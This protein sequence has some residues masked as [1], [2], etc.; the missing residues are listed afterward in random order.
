MSRSTRTLIAAMLLV[1]AGFMAINNIVSAVDI[2]DWL[3]PAVLLVAGLTL[4]FYPDQTAPAPAHEDDEPVSLAA[5]PPMPT[6]AA[7]VPEPVTPPPAPPAP[8][9]PVEAPTKA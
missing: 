1:L 5:A 4:A 3:L 9:A 6:L 8:A 2:G 7:A